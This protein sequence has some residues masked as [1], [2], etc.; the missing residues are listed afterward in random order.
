MACALVGGADD[1]AKDK[2]TDSTLT[3]TWIVARAS[4]GG[5]ENPGL[6][7]DKFK[8]TDDG[9]LTVTSRGRDEQIVF[10]IDATKKPATIDL[11]PSDGPAKGQVL[12]G[13][14]SLTGDE[15]KVSF[16]PDPT[17][18]RPKDF[19]NDKTTT[20]ILAVLTRSK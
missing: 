4:F 13:I 14:Y 18:E 15:L 1:K 10:K 11:T 9:K 16:S 2:K 3:G 12:K 7:G 20:S 6:K 19:T 8:F 17:A 5:Q